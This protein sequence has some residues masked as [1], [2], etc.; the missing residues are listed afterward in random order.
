M[1]EQVKLI[2]LKLADLGERKK[3]KPFS[4]VVFRKQPDVQPAL[5]LPMTALF[6]AF[7]NSQRC[8][9]SGFALFFSSSKCP[10]IREDSCNSCLINSSLFPSAQIRM[11]DIFDYCLL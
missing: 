8:V 9:G 6:L 3:S 1:L 10:Q 5:T 7:D 4:E 11:S 2:P